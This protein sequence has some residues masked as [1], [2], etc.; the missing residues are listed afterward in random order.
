[1]LEGPRADHD[2]QPPTSDKAKGNG[3]G[4]PTHGSH[5]GQ[6]PNASFSSSHVS[7]GL[8]LCT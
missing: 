3:Q 4:E 7:F 8:L 6:L 5:L 2:Q 1:M